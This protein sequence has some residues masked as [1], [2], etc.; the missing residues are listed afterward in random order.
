[1]LMQQDKKIA[2]LLPVYK[3]DRVDFFVLSIDSILSQTYNNIHVFVGVDGPVG[4]EL[5]SCLKRYESRNNISVLWYNKNRGLACVL[6]DLIGEAQKANCDYYARMDSDDISQNDRFERQVSFLE[7][8]RD[9][10]VVGGA[11]EEINSES[12]RNGKRVQYP[13]TNKE[14]RKFFRYRDPMAHPAVMFRP[15][16]FEKVG[17]YRNEYRKNQDTM[18]WF[19]GFRNGC[20][21][22][23]LADTVLYFRV[24]DDFYKS[25]RNGLKRAKKML[26]DRLMINRTLHYDFSAYLFSFAMFIMT[27]MPSPIK[28]LLYRLR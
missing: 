26:K 3:N 11:I 18:L 8:N 1:M 15:T 14:C 23:N 25:R 9:I 13:L 24:T 12:K 22:A 16:Y 20:I 7:R 6:N 10:D 28:K 19:D 4:K 2:V 5:A 27:V 17:G 21:F